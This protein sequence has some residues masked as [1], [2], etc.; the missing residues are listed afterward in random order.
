MTPSPLLLCDA[1]FR[2]IDVAYRDIDHLG[3][4][5]GAFQSLCDPG[6]RIPPGAS[7]IHHIVDADVRGKPKLAALRQQLTAPVYV[8]HNAQFD[9]GFLQLP[10]AWL[11]THRLSKH[12]W[13][14]IKN[15][16]NNEIR[17]HLQLD[18]DLPKDTASHRAAAD[19]AVTSA[20][21]VAALRAG[22]AMAKWP[23]LR[24][25][26]DL[27]QALASPARLTWVPFRAHRD[28]K[29]EDADD[30]LLHWIIQKQAGGEDA[31]HTARSVLRERYEPS[32]AE[33]SESDDD[34][35]F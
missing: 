15:H 30:G 33:V 23:H 3:N 2:I 10:G 19:V 28:T 13:P 17:Y 1:T 14:A 27:E 29:F 12:L 18:V 8:A 20:I 22:V 6:M 11:C 25:V 4:V 32:S 21:L 9:R 24:T 16:S 35:P 26:Q 31:V 5:H 7:A 34:R